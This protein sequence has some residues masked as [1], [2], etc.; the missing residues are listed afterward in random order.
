MIYMCHAGRQP[1]TAEVQDM[2]NGKAD[3]PTNNYL[4]DRFHI[5]DKKWCGKDNEFCVHGH[6][7]VQY[8]IERLN[9]MQQEYTQTNG[10]FSILRYCNGHK[11]DIDLGS[12]NSH[13]ACLLNL[14]TLEPIY[15]KDRFHIGEDND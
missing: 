13:I 1:H 3:I 14:D 10:E 6:T 7:P 4:W 9:F 8:M 12:F 2:H 11:I 15:F 5:Y